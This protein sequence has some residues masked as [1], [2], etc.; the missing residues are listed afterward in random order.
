MSTI[1][2]LTTGSVKGSEAAA[3]HKAS[4]NTM[5]TEGREKKKKRKNEVFPVPEQNISTVRGCLTV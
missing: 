1:S 5:K 4:R 2:H 3:P